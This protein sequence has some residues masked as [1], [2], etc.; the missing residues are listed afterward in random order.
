MFID[1][2]EIRNYQRNSGDLGERS[3][4]PDD[5]T[6]GYLTTIAMP[7]RPIYRSKLQSNR[8]LATH[9]SRVLLSSAKQ[10]V[11]IN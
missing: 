8:T 1:I 10:L 5:S 7:D 3:Y 4:F 2:D 6:L 9:W 11:T